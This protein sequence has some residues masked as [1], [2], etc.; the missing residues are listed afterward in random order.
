[1]SDTIGTAFCNGIEDRHCN[2]LL[3]VEQLYRAGWWQRLAW[4]VGWELANMLT[5]RGLRTDSAHRR[6]QRASTQ[7]KKTEGT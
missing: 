3:R 7:A 5:G 2:G 1:M 4:R 6:K